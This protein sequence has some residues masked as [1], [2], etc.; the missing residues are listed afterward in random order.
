MVTEELKRA[1]RKA[2]SAYGEAIKR[3]W[4]FPAKG[5][6]V[7]NGLE[8]MLSTAPEERVHEFIKWL[9]ER[10]NDLDGE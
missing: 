3:A 5:R 7:A 2:W 8:R 6:I 10:T 1:A 4:H 9:E